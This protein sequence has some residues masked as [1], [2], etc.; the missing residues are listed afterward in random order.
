[1]LFADSEF[2]FLNMKLIFQ[3]TI[4]AGILFCAQV[5]CGLIILIYANGLYSSL[6]S[7]LHNTIVEKYTEGSKVEKA[8]D[9]LQSNFGCC[10]ATNHTDWAHTGWYSKMNTVEMKRQRTGRHGESALMFRVILI[11]FNRTSA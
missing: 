1:M 3:L 5:L 11:R 7:S 6:S 4:S 8:M 10:G 2:S 9:M